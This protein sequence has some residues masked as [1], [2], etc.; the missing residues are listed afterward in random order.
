MHFC[1][2]FVYQNV[3]VLKQNILRIIIEN[4]IKNNNVLNIML[5]VYS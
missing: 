2:R 1:W 3:C 4:L 5:R